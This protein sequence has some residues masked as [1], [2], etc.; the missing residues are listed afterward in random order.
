MAL[1]QGCYGIIY[2]QIDVCIYIC[3]VKTSKI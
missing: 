2:I 3:I 1:D